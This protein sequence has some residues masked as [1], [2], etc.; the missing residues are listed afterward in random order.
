ME[1]GI[2]PRNSSSGQ[3]N[4]GFNQQTSPEP[5][6]DAIEL[7]I[8]DEALGHSGFYA[9]GGGKRSGFGRQDELL[10][11]ICQKMAAF[12]QHLQGLILNKTDS[13]DDR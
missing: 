9:L 13:K 2:R 5:F 7:Q 1:P 4:D 11:G 6:R 8:P 10:Q 12:H 3:K